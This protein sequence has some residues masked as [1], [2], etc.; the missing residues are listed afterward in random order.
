MCGRNGE[1]PHNTPI[2]QQMNH[3]KTP[4]TGADMFYFH[5]VHS[6]EMKRGARRE[7]AQASSLIAE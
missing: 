7:R 5:S 3:Q 6:A 4:Q 1:L 2:S